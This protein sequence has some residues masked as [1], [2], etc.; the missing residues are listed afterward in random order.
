MA[1]RS[2]VLSSKNLKHWE[3]YDICK[4]HNAKMYEIHN[5]H[6]RNGEGDK[7]MCE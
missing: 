4:C 2:K 6:W 5:Q 1:Q 3:K 7:I